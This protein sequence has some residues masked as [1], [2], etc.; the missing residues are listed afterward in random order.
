MVMRHSQTPESSHGTQAKNPAWL[1]KFLHN[2]C[3]NLSEL[4][5]WCLVFWL[6]SKVPRHCQRVNDLYK[7]DKVLEHL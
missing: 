6:T 1:C 2:K 4:H 3:Y 5:L 7:G